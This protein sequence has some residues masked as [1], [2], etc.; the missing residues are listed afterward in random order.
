MALIYPGA[1]SGNRGF[2]PGSP[3]GSINTSWDSSSVAAAS[4]GVANKFGGQV[5]TRSTGATPL[6]LPMQIEGNMTRELIKRILPSD[7]QI[8]SEARYS[9]K[10]QIRILIDDEGLS[11]GDAAGIPAGQGVNL[12]TFNPIPLPNAAT[13]TSTTANGGGR[14]LWR[15]NDN[16]T[17]FSNSYNEACIS[18]FLQHA[19]AEWRSGTGRHCSRHQG[20]PPGKGHHRGLEN[21]R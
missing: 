17:S 10:S 1:S 18:G 5:L 8:L 19:A 6:L 20:G 14:A 9:S 15:I 4:S 2:F 3:D 13:N 12:S 16:N 7:T 11:A 21:Q